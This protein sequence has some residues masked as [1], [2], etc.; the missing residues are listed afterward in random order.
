ML[1]YHEKPFRLDLFVQPCY[2]VPVLL[3]VFA[4]LDAT[5]NFSIKPK[6]EHPKQIKIADA[7]K[8]VHSKIATKT[9]LHR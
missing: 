9:V 1:N 4:S 7:S 2:K 5:H 8:I 6:S 3:R